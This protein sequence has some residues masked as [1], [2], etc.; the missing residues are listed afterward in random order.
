MPT[1]LTGPTITDSTD[2]VPQ[3]ENSASDDLKHNEA[4]VID[5]RKP[6]IDYL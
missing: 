1:D 4:D 2:L 3:V 6:I 5:W